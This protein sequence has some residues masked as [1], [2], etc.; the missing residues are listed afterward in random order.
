MK[1]H[2]FPNSKLH[3]NPTGLFCM[4]SPEACYGMKQC[5]DKNCRLCYERLDLTGRFEP[6]MRFSNQQVHRF[7]NNYQVYLNRD[8]VS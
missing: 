2:T 4:T 6:A 1:T 7:L 8:V 3:S 5:P